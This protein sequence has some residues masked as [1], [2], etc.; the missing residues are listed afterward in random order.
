MMKGNIRKVIATI[1]AIIMLTSLCSCASKPTTA[2]ETLYDY[3][4]VLGWT[5][6]HISDFDDDH[7]VNLEVQ[8]WSSIKLT[9]DDD[10][11]YLTTDI[12]WDNYAKELDK[13][14][15]SVTYKG[16]DDEPYIVVTYLSAGSNT[17]VVPVL[18]VK[19]KN[20]PSSSG[21]KLGTLKNG[22]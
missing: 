10:T 13:N 7:S 22:V 8:S 3:I 16:A 15:P 21:E 4:P 6:W 17:S 11:Y 2:Q 14:G 12:N 1:S 5:E 9:I 20:Y 19:I 18:S